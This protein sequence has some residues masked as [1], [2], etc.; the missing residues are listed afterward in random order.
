MLVVGELIRKSMFSYQDSITDCNPDLRHLADA[1]SM[2][3]AFL[4]LT[5]TCRKMSRKA[6]R[7]W[8]QIDRASSQRAK[9]SAKIGRAHV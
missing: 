6:N 1:V 9:Y 5:E 3:L 2:S 8:L 4:G 7:L